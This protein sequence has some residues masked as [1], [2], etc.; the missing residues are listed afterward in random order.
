MQEESIKDWAERELFPSPR[1]DEGGYTL[2][3]THLLQ[4]PQISNNNEPDLGYLNVSTV[5]TS[6]K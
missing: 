1:L 5:K 3:T 4:A 2:E 6:L